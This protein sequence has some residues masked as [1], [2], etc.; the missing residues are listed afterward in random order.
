V[1]LR[2]LVNAGPRFRGVQATAPVGT[3]FKIAL[4]VARERIVLTATAPGLTA[5]PEGVL[6]G[7]W[8]SECVAES[9]PEPRLLS[10]SHAGPRGVEAISAAFGES[11]RGWLGISVSPSRSY[12][13]ASFPAGF[14]TDSLVPA[15]FGLVGTPIEDERGVPATLRNRHASQQLT[16]LDG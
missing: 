9:D 10:V 8:R 4:G 3:S 6:P 11:G 16:R 5:L 13:R 1:Q 7:Q 15:D 2:L 12:A 14:D